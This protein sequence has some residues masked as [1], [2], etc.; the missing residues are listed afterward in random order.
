LGEINMKTLRIVAACAAALLVGQAWAQDQP[1]TTTTMTA[2]PAQDVGGVTDI[3]RSDA[4]APMGLTRQQ[5]YQDL[6]HSERSGEQSRLQELYH[7][8]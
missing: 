1:A 8:Q 2:Q 6:V 4:G 3:S 7:G 5:V